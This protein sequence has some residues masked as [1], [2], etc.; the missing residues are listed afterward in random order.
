MVSGI[1]GTN[2]VSPDLSTKLN[3]EDKI[4]ATNKQ[5]YDE[6]L[7]MARKYLQTFTGV[8]I[9]TKEELRIDTAPDTPVDLDNEV[10]PVASEDEEIQSPVII[11]PA[12]TEPE[13][14]TVP[15]S[16]ITNPSEHSLRF[17]TNSNITPIMVELPSGE[18]KLVSPIII[19]ST[20]H[21]IKVKTKSKDL[22]YVIAPHVNGG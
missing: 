5:L 15:E 6:N 18:Q 13:V 4:I 12:P 22:F 1:Q 19:G 21:V 9:I 10:I 20:G 16:V 7:A 14:I 3:Q 11:A 17:P 8:P 2:S